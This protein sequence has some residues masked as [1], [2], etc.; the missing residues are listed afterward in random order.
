MTRDVFRPTQQ[1]AQAI[2]DAFQAEAAHRRNRGIDEW[3]L[4]ERTAVWR[5]AR[6]AA[7][8][9]GWRVL[10]LEEVRRAEDQAAGHTDYGAKWAYAVVEAMRRP[11]PAVRA[12]A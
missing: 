8:Q 5:A 2:Y 12:A 4:A 3:L 1:P 9:L 7:Q 6:D 11:A 10:T